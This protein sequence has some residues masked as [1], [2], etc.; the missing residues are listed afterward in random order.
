MLIPRLEN[1]F[2]YKCNGKYSN[3]DIKR[4]IFKINTI[5]GFGPKGDC[6]KWRGSGS[7]PG[8]CK[9]GKF[10]LNTITMVATHV[11]IETSTGILIPEGMVVRHK[12]DFTMCVNPSHLLI[13]TQQDNIN[14]KV[15]RNRQATKESHGMSKINLEIVKQIRYLYDNENYTQM[16]LEH[17]FNIDQ[18]VI[19]DI[20]M[21]K[22]WHDENYVP[23]KSKIGRNG[24]SKL[25]L[26]IANEIRLFY[27]T[28]NY[29]YKNLAKIFDVNEYTIGDIINHRS[30]RE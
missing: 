29:T 18:T 4:F 9:Y 17:K 20:V 7:G 30:W 11:S 19:S 16:Q 12:C 8:L 2:I 5:P 21:N 15:S 3:K 14:D 23:S 1:I 13:G 26:E 24:N 10:R 28:G 6:W 22:L 27:S 25:S